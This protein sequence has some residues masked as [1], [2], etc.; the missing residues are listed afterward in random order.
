MNA[1][2]K[3]THADYGRMGGAPM[4]TG[5]V[6]STNGGVL[7]SLHITRLKRLAEKATGRDREHLEAAVECIRILTQ[8]NRR[9]GAQVGA[10]M[11]RKVLNHRGLMLS[12]KAQDIAEVAADRTVHAYRSSRGRVRLTTAA[13]LAASDEGKRIGTYD[14]GCDYRH[15][16]EDVR[17]ALAA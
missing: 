6:T 7:S 12:G 8:R 15:I 3:L 2:R 9:M 11:K 5:S 17:E 4:T 10:T 14:A 16:V 13:R 1:E